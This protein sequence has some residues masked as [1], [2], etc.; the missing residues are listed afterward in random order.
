MVVGIAVQFQ[1]ADF[2]AYVGGLSIFFGIL[3]GFVWY[4]ITIPNVEKEPF[5]F[6]NIENCSSE[7]K[8]SQSS[9]GLKKPSFTNGAFELDVEQQATN[10]TNTHK[11][12][13][14]EF[15]VQLQL[16]TNQTLERQS[17]NSNSMD[18]LENTMLPDSPQAI[19]SN[20]NSNAITTFNAIAVE[21]EKS[22]T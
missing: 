6:D 1:S 3:F 7:G 10:K 19:A 9:S 14:S 18:D 4:M 5:V 2:M 21:R 22:H 12:S 13:I 8:V 16:I 11:D 17:N 15:D 20:S